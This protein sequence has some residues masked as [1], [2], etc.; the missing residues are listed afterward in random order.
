MYFMHH[1][2]CKICIHIRQQVP[3][4]LLSWALVM[5]KVVYLDHNSIIVWVRRGEDRVT[6]RRW[7][8]KPLQTALFVQFLNAA[9]FH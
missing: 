2:V 7:V 9:F 8:D 5:T 3:Q 1:K 4:I 6:L